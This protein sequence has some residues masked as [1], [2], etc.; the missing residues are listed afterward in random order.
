MPCAW[1]N[2]NNKKPTFLKSSFRTLQLGSRARSLFKIFIASEMGPRT[3]GL[4]GLLQL[5]IRFV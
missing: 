3:P 4:D 1:F 5:L 2:N